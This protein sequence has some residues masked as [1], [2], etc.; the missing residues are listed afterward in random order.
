MGPPGFG[1]FFTMT[2]YFG[3]KPK[4]RGL[5]DQ[6]GLP[7]YTFPPDYINRLWS[8]IEKVDPVFAEEYKKFKEAER[9][10]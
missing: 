9:K 3:L 6:D 5:V 8:S 1:L 10:Q 7:M 2:M 4:E